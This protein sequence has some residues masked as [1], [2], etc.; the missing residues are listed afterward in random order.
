MPRSA[1]WWRFS[2]KRDIIV[3][4]MLLTPWRSHESEAVHLK[5]R[6]LDRPAGECG[7]A[8]TEER[9]VNPMLKVYFIWMKDSVDTHAT[10]LK[11]MSDKQTM[12][13]IET[14]LRKRSR[15][16]Q[17]Y[18][19]PLTWSSKLNNVSLRVIARFYWRKIYRTWRVVR[20]VRGMGTASSTLKY[21]YHLFGWVKWEE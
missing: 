1:V 12:S 5:D 2:I 15:Y 20:N 6:W 17:G 16:L 3:T 14:N 10:Q 18:T 9:L 19:Q 13:I 8:S 21:A 7:Q 11:C 4:D